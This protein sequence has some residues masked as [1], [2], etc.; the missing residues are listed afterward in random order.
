MMNRTNFAV[1]GISVAISLVAA[2]TLR[3]SHAQVPVKAAD[4]APARFSIS[5]EVLP[6]HLSM[7]IIYITDSQTNKLHIYRAIGG[8]DLSFKDDPEL[9]RTFDLTSVGEKKLR[10]SQ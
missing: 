8:M 10:Q 2:F 7:T 9:Y 1:I 4:A 3:P 5:T 6:G